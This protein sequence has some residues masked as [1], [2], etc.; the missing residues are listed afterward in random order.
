M[1]DVPRAAIAGSLPIE[2][3]DRLAAP[4]A[5]AQS[6]L[7]AAGPDG[8]L[9]LPIGE[10]PIGI[11]VVDAD[12]RIVEA[13]RSAR[14]SFGIEGL[15]GTRL[16]DA[17]HRIWPGAFAVEAIGRFRATLASGEA[18]GARD[19][20]ERRGDSGE[21]EA[22][23]WR[24]ERI[25]MPDGCF[26]VLCTFHDWSERQRVEAE[27]RASERR[28]LQSD[29][30][31]RAAIGTLE[32]V[33]WTNNAV[34]E[35]VG[36]Q[37]GWAALTGQSLDQYQ[38]YGWASAVHP[39]DVQATVDA[40]QR[41]VAA[42]GTFVFEH[43]VRRY[44]GQWRLFSVRANPILDSAGAILEWVGIH[45]DIT[46]RRATETE[47]ARLAAIVEQS[48]DFIGAADLA[49]QPVFLNEA[50][51][52]LVG[53]AGMEAVRQ[54]DILAFFTPASRELMVETV[55]PAVR[56]LGVWSGE[57]DL[58][59]FGTGAT[60]PVLYTLFPFRDEGGVAGYATVTRDLTERKRSEG[61]LRLLN[62]QLETRVADAVT[63]REQ[64]Q[65]MLAQAQ[66]LEALGQLA[67]G[68]AHD[69]NNVLQVVS[70][71]LRL[72]LKKAS[73]P[74]AVRKL[75]GMTE[76]AARRGAS[77]T[78]RLLAF[79]RRDELQA[80]SVSPGPLLEGLREILVSTL[81][82]DIAVEV[83]AK[84][85]TPALLADKAQLETVLI[86]LAV[87]ARDAMPQGGTL[88]IAIDAE[89]VAAGRG[90]PV[91]L[92]AGA[93]LRID[94]VD[95]GHGMDAATLKRASE[96]FFTT[97]PVGQ[98][99]GLGLAMARGFAEQSGGGFA[100]RSAPGEG[101]T[102][103]LWFPKASGLPAGTAMADP[104]AAASGPPARALVVDDDPMVRQML[105]LQLAALGFEIIQAGDGLDALAHLDAGGAVD[106]LITDLSMPG[107]NGLV[108]IEEARLRRPE[109]PA[110]LLTGYADARH[111]IDDATPDRL[112]VRLR[113]PV[114]D[115]ELAR[116]AAALLAARDAAGS[117]A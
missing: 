91:G 114:S 107:M 62:E 106:L 27:L 76:D 108:L 109:L 89:T 72:I 54:T 21:I 61:A 44:D 10:L 111:R 8:A 55:L 81:G 11:Y 49:M 53:L 66:R 26:G 34:G 74:D 13:S 32:G 23:D 28:L 4:A 17:L 3:A 85:D 51:Q 63:A 20:V 68:I 75:A 48:S 102:V 82:A 9:C 16:E 12:L 101:T 59:H 80:V 90:D 70:G 112:T 2:T 103:T 67:G 31:L 6:K 105:A 110:I 98:G 45:T 58:R 38:G 33:L 92:P 64:A 52:R 37:P 5:A 35:M 86:N 29:A 69:F 43:R 30:R 41:S 36:E 46:A 93:Y 104:A 97:K 15:I 71:G 60:I 47:R 39:D 24:I 117:E 116:R 115:D 95:T 83:R 22:Y 99:T 94:L 56:S 18:Y 87:N 100:L 50:G 40:W 78:A 14:R 19:T 79:A 42:R 77:I 113:K 65:S 57:L 88:A 1:H 96:P 25:V 7:V 73:D 84:P